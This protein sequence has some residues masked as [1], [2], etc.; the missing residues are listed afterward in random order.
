MKKWKRI[1]PTIV[2]KVG[3][4]TVVS[5]TF[6]MPDG[7]IHHWE[8]D[9]P[10]NS[11]AAAVLPLTSDNK[12]VVCRQFRAGPEMV[13][14]E[15]PGGYVGEAEDLETGARRELLEETGYEPGSMHYLGVMRYSAGDNLERHCFM[16]TGCEPS[17]NKGLQDKEEFIEVKLI[18]VDE[19][20]ANA[21]AGKMTD[22][23][24]VLLAY[25]ELQKRRDNK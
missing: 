25:E 20:I 18:S 2:S 1:E 16:A 22:P 21:K 8:T 14:D 15:L 4:K 3:F 5:K 12:V 7:S 24:A 19:L 13:M 11:R 6:E 9:N 17:K 10:I 23:G